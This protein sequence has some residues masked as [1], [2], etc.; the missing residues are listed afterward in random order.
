M[1]SAARKRTLAFDVRTRRF[2]FALFEGPDE[3]L[4]WGVRSF[5]RGVNAVKVPASQKIAIL[6]FEV[7]PH[8]VVIEKTSARDNA[9]LTQTIVR[10]A[11]KENVPVCQIPNPWIRKPASAKPPSKHEVAK[12]LCERFPELADRL[13]PKRKPWQS[14]DYRMSIFDATALG[15]THLENQPEHR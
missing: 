15:L 6:L 12:A 10:L 14:E 9:W 1:I 5:R 7:R 11:G 13:P 4:D 8:T 2:G 3:L